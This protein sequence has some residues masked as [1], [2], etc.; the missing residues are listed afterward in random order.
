M[1]DLDEAKYEVITE[2]VRIPVSSARKAIRLARH[3][4]GNGHNRAS[5]CEISGSI[6]QAPR[7]LAAYRQVEGKS[8]KMSTP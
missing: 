8:R 4:C 2:S 3:L 5:A 7:T 6:Y 1:R